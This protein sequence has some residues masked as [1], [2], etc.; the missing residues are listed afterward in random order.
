MSQKSAWPVWIRTTESFQSHPRKS[1]NI[2]KFWSVQRKQT[3]QQSIGLRSKIK[4]QSKILLNITQDKNWL[5]EGTFKNKSRP[6]I[7]WWL[8]Q[9]INK[10]RIISLEDW[11][12]SI[13][14]KGCIQQYNKQQWLLTQKQ[15]PAKNQ[16]TMKSK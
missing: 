5:E 10:T 4:P 9:R 15:Y 16:Q 12:Q 6:S 1:T 3:S 13:N 14:D 11:L 8:K 7:D 2:N